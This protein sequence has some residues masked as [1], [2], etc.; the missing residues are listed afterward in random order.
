MF[1]TENVKQSNK[2]KNHREQEFVMIFCISL[3][4]TLKNSGKYAIINQRL[5]LIYQNKTEHLTNVKRS[6]LLWNLMIRNL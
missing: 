4:I 1:L 2:N 3:F 6:Y 5:S